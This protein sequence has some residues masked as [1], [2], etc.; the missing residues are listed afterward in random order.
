MEI[1]ERAC[2]A[3]VGWFTGDGFGSQT[4]GMEPS[5]IEENVEGQISEVYTLEACG[6]ACGR[7]SVV[8]DLPVI[9]ALSVEANDTFDIDHV[10]AGYRRY[11]KDATEPLS[12]RMRQALAE[13]A[14]PSDDAL[15]LGRVVPWSLL[16]ISGDRRL[17]R[18]SFAS[19]TALAHASPLVQEVA[20]LFGNMLAMLISGDLFGKDDLHARMLAMA[21]K[22]HVDPRIIAELNAARNE[23]AR[24]D[25][26]YPGTSVL[27]TLRLVLSTFLHADGIEAGMDAIARRG[28]HARLNCALHGA[29]VGA[30]SG[31]DAIPSRWVDELHPSV[32]LE[33]YIKRLTL[34]KR[35]QIR[36]DRLAVSTANIL[37]GR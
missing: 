22:L 6:D 14:R 28:A 18:R 7:S 30:M 36:M 5:W 37:L 21:Q 31:F 4:D 8:S 23:H 24:Q 16:L 34:S 35:Q 1:M 9:L 15:G 12:E 10:R 33:T 25:V 11:L 13:D 17:D 27:T 32:S 3:L 29:L 19:E 2:G 20:Q 26:I